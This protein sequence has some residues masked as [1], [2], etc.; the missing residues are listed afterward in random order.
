[1]NSYYKRLKVEETA[2]SADIKAAF[3]SLAQKFHPDL[4]P[5]DQAKEEEF[6]RLSE[7]YEQLLD[8]VS[9]RKH[10]EDLKT[11]RVARLREKQD[12]ASPHSAQSPHPQGRGSGS[13]QV[14]VSGAPKWRPP[15]G[16]PITSFRPVQSAPSGNDG[17][18][19]VLKAAGLFGGM[20]F[21]ARLLSDSGTHW[22]PT[23]QRRRGRDGRFRPS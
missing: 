1:M 18:G 22:D 2:S 9:R 4:H 8:P 15:S 14:P 5:G 6:K 10:D 7:A 11:S 17:L 12:V 19:Q 3:R 23:V 21:L 16:P 20:F 13:S